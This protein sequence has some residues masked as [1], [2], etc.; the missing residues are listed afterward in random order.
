MMKEVLHDALG[1]VLHSLK[2]KTDIKLEH[3]PSLEFGHFAT[4]VALQAARDL[5]KSPRDVALMILE[6]LPKS[7]IKNFETSIAGPGFI[8]FKATP[9]YLQA[10]LKEILVKKDKAFTFPKKRENINLEF[11]SANPTGP[12]TLANGRGGFYGD[13]LGNV[14]AAVGYNV[15][16]EFYIN[17]SGNQMKMLGSAVRAALGLVPDEEEYYHGR[18]IATWAK[19]HKEEIAKRL[20]T[21]PEEEGRIFADYILAHYI[22]PVVGKRGMHIMFDTWFSEYAELH[23][24]KKIEKVKQELIKKGLTY[25]AEG[26]LWLKTTLEGDDKDRV[27]ITKEG[28]PTYFLVDIA[29]LLN[30]ISRKYNRG[31][32]ILG[33]DHHGY[34]PRLRAVQALLGHKDWLRILITQFARLMKDGQEFAMSKRRGTYV[35]MDELLDEVGHDAAR[36]FFLLHA[37]NTHMDFDADLAKK[38]SS[39]NPV[40]Y[41]KYAHARMASILKKARTRA[42]FDVKKV[43]YSLLS[44]PHELELI[45]ELTKFKDLLLD[46]G[47]SYEVHRLPHYAIALADKFHRFYE[48][49]R[50]ITDDRN[51]TRARLA[52]LLGTKLVL[53]KVL[54]IMGIE[55]PDKM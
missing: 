35:A 3:P 43:D 22:K 23:K 50:V 15:H 46:I 45:F 52:L 12:L 42:K 37:L 40:F 5:E 38:K 54:G 20:D 34:I 29:Y 49:S 36:F 32:L 14:L 8:N 28:T 9:A 30:K 21:P 17:D 1:K 13:A 7:I 11:L 24:K 26:A 2:V 6:N 27:I 10:V 39:K 48:H 18:Y 41:V 4:N 33:A 44:D 55:A 47:E 51:L 31:I 16:R 25:K 19:E 53:A